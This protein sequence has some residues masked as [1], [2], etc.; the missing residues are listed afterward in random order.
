MLTIGAVLTD[1]DIASDPI[2]ENICIEGCS[3]CIKNC[4]VNAIDETGVKQKEC[5]LNTYGKTKRGYGTVDCNKCRTI[6]PGRYG[7]K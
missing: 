1:M 3:L 5:R 6:C 4:P 2:S 7:V